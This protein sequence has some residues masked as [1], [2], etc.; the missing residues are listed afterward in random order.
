MV[1]ES[2]CIVCK[3]FALETRILAQALQVMPASTLALCAGL[4]VPKPEEKAEVEPPR[5]K[6]VPIRNFG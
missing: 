3:S 6:Y 5:T 2:H 4:G 1:N